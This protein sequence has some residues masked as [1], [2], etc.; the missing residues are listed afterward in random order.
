MNRR[1]VIKNPIHRMAGAIA[2]R[3]ET[4]DPSDRPGRPQAKRT[5]LQQLFVGRSLENWE[6]ALHHFHLR[7]SSGIFVNIQPRT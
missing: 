4:V 1:D 2:S 5:G 7:G 6:S 3:R